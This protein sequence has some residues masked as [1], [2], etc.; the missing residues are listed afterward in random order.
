MS[1]RKDNEHNYRRVQQYYNVWPKG[2][3][4]DCSQALGLS[5][6]TVRRHRNRLVG[7]QERMTQIAV[8]TNNHQLAEAQ[9]LFNLAA[10]EVYWQGA[11][12]ERLQAMNDAWNKLNDLQSE[13]G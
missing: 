1:T 2:T 11:T 4:A 3:I 12:I 7:R 13:V 10:M 8:S 5:E 6:A 9:Q